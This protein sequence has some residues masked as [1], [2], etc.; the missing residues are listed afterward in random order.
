MDRRLRTDALAC[1]I[2][3]ALTLTALQSGPIFDDQ[4]AAAVGAERTGATAAVDSGWIAGTV[5]SLEGNVP[6]RYANVIAVGTT[7]GAMTDSTGT[8]LMHVPA[9][10]YSIRAMMMRQRNRE[11]ANVVVTPNDTTRVVLQ[12]EPLGLTE[13]EARAESIGVDVRVSADDLRCEIVPLRPRYN[14]GDRPAFGVRIYNESD[15][16]F[17]L[18]PTLD[19]SE[20][21]ARYPNVEWLITGPDGGVER[22]R[23]LYCGNLNSLQPADFIWVEAGSVFDPYQG[24]GFTSLEQTVVLAR[25][26]TYKVTFRYSTDEGDIRRWLGDWAG[27]LSPIISEQIRRVPRVV[28]TAST[29]IDVEE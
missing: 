3:A 21:G 15:Q 17:F 28:L 13:A 5:F 22:A 1:G 26:G 19:G 4:P 29:T 11:L 16:G 23:M 10:S 9:G 14:V 25:P 6:Q 8:F 18:V 20:R 2:A 24:A 12:L 7:M 27:H